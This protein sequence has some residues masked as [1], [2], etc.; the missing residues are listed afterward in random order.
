VCVCRGG[1]GGYV[2][3]RT[4]IFYIKIYHLHIQVMACG[5]PQAVSIYQVSRFAKQFDIPCI[6]D[7]GIRSPGH[8]MKAL[9]MGAS[10]VMMGSMLAG[11]HEAP[12][13]CVFMCIC[14]YDCMYVCMYVCMC[15]CMKVC[16]YHVVICIYV[17]VYIYKCLYV[18]VQIHI[19]VCVWVYTHTHTYMYTHIYTQ[20]CTHAHTH[21]HTHTHMHAHIHTQKH[22]HTHTNTHA[23]RRLVLSRRHPHEEIQGHGVERGHGKGV[24]HPLPHEQ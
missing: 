19:H 16:M 24:K 17:Y 9:A 2:K 18:Y 10:A 20:T 7:G 21:T 22:T 8:I 14:M 5:R 15:T 4:Y 13:V 3:T 6:A 23:H 11:T 12:G 1:W